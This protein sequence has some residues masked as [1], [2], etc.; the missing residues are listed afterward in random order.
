MR[1]FVATT[2]RTSAVAAGDVMQPL[3][4]DA[5]QPDAPYASVKDDM[6]RVIDLALRADGPVGVAD[7]EGVVVGVIILADILKAVRG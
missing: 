7:E 6:R 5:V 3:S 1:A 4:P 2:P